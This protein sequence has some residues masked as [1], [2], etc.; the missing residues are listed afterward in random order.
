MAYQTPKTNWAAGQVPAP[1][2][3]N[4]IEGNVEVI[5]KLRGYPTTTGS[6][7]AIIVTTGYFEL[8]DGT[9]F[10]FIASANNGAAATTINADGTGA[11]P[12]YKPGGTSAPNF[13]AGKAYTVW[14]STSNSCFFIKASAEGDAAAG[15]VLASKKFSNDN[16]SGITGI[17]PNNGAVAITP[18]V[19]TQ[20]ISAGYHNG[21]G[22][23]ASLG[24]DAAAAH[25]LTGKT[26][27]SNVAGR[28][29]AGSMTDRSGA[30]IPTTETY[31]VAGR[32]N[33]KVPQGYWNGV[34]YIYSDDPDFVAA[35]IPSNKNIFGLQGNMPVRAND[36]QALQTWTDAVGTLFF[37]MPTG[38]YLTDS[39]FGAGKAS[40]AFT[41][42]DFIA[43]NILAGKNVF[44]VEG[45]AKRQASGTTFVSGAINAWFIDKNGNGIYNYYCEV[46]GLGFN[47]GNL[48][49]NY[50]Y[51]TQTYTVIASTKFSNI[52]STSGSD[53]AQ[54]AVN[55]GGYWRFGG[56]STMTNG[57]KI[58]VMHSN[59]NVTWYAYE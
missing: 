22:T 6:G 14:Y 27:S 16:D 11:M 4:R 31:P 3:F 44:G 52:Y 37:A 47:V 30:D 42:P 29:A 34:N 54:I 15:D 12:V 51:G 49:M 43:A 13:I 2:D 46:S 26:F 33:L 36:Q 58:P 21:A 59:M 19:S 55:T 24:G 35:N 32:L 56:E 50:V 45:T 41:D 7:T 17:M 5:S 57:F 39:G 48:M 18:N 25:V 38:A 23:V 53:Y 10:T 28:A 1:A 20:N 8:T 40:V 9:A